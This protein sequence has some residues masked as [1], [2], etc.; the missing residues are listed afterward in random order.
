MAV[1]TARNKRTHAGMTVRLK[2]LWSQASRNPRWFAMDS[3]SRFAAVRHSMRAL[4]SRPDLD[5]Y[6]L[7]RS[8]IPNVDAQQFLQ[9]LHGDGYCHG[10]TLP[11]DVLEELQR[12]ASTATC[13]GDAN[14]RYGFKYA[15]KS[16][17]Q[18]HSQRVFSQATYLFLDEMQPLIDSVANDPLLCRIAASYMNASPVITGSRLWWVFATPEA[19]FD[20]SLTT[21]FF[22]Y[23]KDDYAALRMF[24]YV[25]PVLDDDHGPHVVVSGSHRQKQWSQLFS[26]GQRG[27]RGILECYGKDR[28]HTIYGDAGA[29]FA[30]DPFCFHKATRPHVG[31]RLMLE[32]KY[33]TRNFNIF[34]RPDRALARNVAV[35]KIKVLQAGVARSSRTGLL[36][37]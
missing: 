7:S 12:F 10:L 28:V 31:D 32:I 4:Q 6:D 14:S 17:A 37:E 13:Y 8:R 20:S 3:L 1:T 15:D 24:F 34:P 18:L 33:A 5:R 23:D 9:T 25:T 21:S 2:T 35:P 19:D 11:A 22:H 36:V 30:E 16:A 26:L 29:G 27:D